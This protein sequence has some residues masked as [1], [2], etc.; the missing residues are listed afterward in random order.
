MTSK[1]V[2]NTIEA[3]TG[4]SSVSFASSISLSS[5]S[6]FHFSA[7]GIDIDADTNIKRPAAGV[8]A[9][10]IN[11]SEK[12]RI[13]SNGQLGIGTNN[14]TQ[15]IEVQ[16]R[17]TGTVC[18][19]NVGTQYGN[20]HFGGYNNYPAIMNSGNQPLIY[21]DT[22]NDRTVLFGDT[23]GFGTTCAFRVNN[24]ERLRI[25]STGMVLIGETSVA[26]GSQKLVIGNG[27]AENMEFTPGTSAQNGGVLEYIHRGDTATRPD[28]SMYVGGGAFK[29]YTGGNDERL[30][31]GSTGKLTF[32][33]DAAENNL[34]DIDFRT[35]AGLQIRG[36]DGNANNAKL[37]LGGSNLNQRKTAIIHDPVGGYCRG[38][39]HFC[40][41]NA[42]DVSDVDVT[43]SKMV[44]KADGKLLL[45]TTD[46]GYAAS[47]TNMV[48]G[49]NSES[50]S[51]ITIASSTSGIGRIHFADNNTG[52]AV[53]AGWIAYNHSSNSMLFST[54]GSG[55]EKITIASNGRLSAITAATQIN[56]G[57]TI[58]KGGFLLSTT[59]GQFSISGGGY[60]AGSNWV[61]TATAST[62]IRHD[63]GTGPMKFCFNTG[64]TAG[65]NF[66]PTTR[67]EITPSG[68][69]RQGEVGVTMSDS[70]PYFS[71]AW[72]STDG[73]NKCFTIASSRYATLR[74]KGEQGSNAEFTQGTGDG[75]FYMCY[76]ENQNAH[77]ITCPANGVLTGNFSG[78]SDEKMKKNITSLADNAITRIKQLRPVNFDWKRESDL[79]G[80]SGFIAQEVKTVIPDLVSGEE[81]DET[82]WNSI[83]YS[84]NYDGMIAHLTKALQEAITEI[85]TLKTKVAA[86]EG[87]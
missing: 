68:D 10:N 71:N 52:N 85:E 72:S 57:N 29:V 27:G 12:V 65:N 61:A 21:C 59:D 62:Q 80:Q 22:N 79:N 37:Y 26:G 56:F 87:S 9:F 34:A 3:D 84:I 50:N 63:G 2:V 5:T 15:L 82:Q 75:T 53:H 31:I 11:S 17:S 14:P 33:Y 13:N 73:Y 7:A 28:L 46:A 23:V 1:L 20:A 40:L 55:S 64:L 6:K 41:E 43:D 30:R 4:I 48:I 32:D 81:Y 69:M 47:Y 60:W 49:S 35:N 8:L 36:F 24:A 25:T 74:M 70:N 45:A 77:R 18:G 44:I 67:F 54:N 16:N 51:G 38:D 19:L 42:A 39:L 86:L 58:G 78:S 83:G 66:T 76:D